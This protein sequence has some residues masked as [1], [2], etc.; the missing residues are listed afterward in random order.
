MH[1]RPSE[2]KELMI[3][4][5]HQNGEVACCVNSLTQ[6]VN[7]L[8]WLLFSFAS[9]VLRIYITSHSKAPC[10]NADVDTGHSG[11]MLRHNRMRRGTDVDHHVH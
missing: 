7:W 11:Y 6:T 1:L 3:V 8:V 4:E 9:V 10:I 2:A 5:Q